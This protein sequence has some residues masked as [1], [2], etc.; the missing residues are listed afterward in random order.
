MSAGAYNIEADQGATWAEVWTW[1]DSGG[2]PVDLSGY[3]AK[4]EWATEQGDVV[5][6]LTESSGI[7]LGGAMGTISPTASAT[8]TSL[9]TPGVY[10]YDLFLQNSGGVVI[11][12]LSGLVNV[13]GRTP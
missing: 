1:T 5:L 11:K 2:V 9:L 4:L 3:T 12:L 10:V 6:S 8:Q 7:V 13:S